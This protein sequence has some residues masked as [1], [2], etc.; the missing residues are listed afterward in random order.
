MLGVP[1]RKK[2][3]RLTLDKDAATPAAVDE[4]CLQ[5]ISV[6]LRAGLKGSSLVF[7]ETL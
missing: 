3:L 6:P 7:P 1:A 2:S 5:R 4:E